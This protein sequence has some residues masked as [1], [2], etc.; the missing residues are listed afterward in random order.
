MIK[1]VRDKSNVKPQILFK[2]AFRDI[3]DLSST[4][5][6]SEDKTP[7]VLYCLTNY[8]FLDALLRE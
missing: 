8:Y 4:F 6:S 7:F 2:N 3:L 5:A 1:T